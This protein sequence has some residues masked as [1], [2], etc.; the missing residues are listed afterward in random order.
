[1]SKKN[2]RF[3]KRPQDT[4]NLAWVSR[5]EPEPKSERKP[6]T[7][8]RCHGEKQVEAYDGTMTPCGA[9]LGR[10][11]PPEPCPECGSEK[12]K[13][14]VVIGDS[15]F[16]W[17]CRNCGYIPSFF[18]KEFDDLEALELWDENAREMRGEKEDADNDQP[19]C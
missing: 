9:C 17:R 13:I 4:K 14:F 15:T 8:W 7:C 3:F 1:M 16:G 5:K 12:V 18:P 11:K 6:G 2:N 19:G 10:D